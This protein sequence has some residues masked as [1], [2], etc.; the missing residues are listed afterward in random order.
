M[1]VKIVKCIL[2]Y[3]QNIATYIHQMQN[4]TIYTHQTQIWHSASHHFFL[5]I[6]V[7]FTVV[8]LLFLHLSKT[9]S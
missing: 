1:Y 9:L 4:I 7:E 6:P 5:P 8:R 3:G 2:I